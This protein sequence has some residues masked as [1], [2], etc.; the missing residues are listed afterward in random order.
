MSVTFAPWEPA[1]GRCHGSARPGATALMKVV[2][3][4]LDGLKSW[5]IY[6]CRDTALGNPSAHGDGRALDIGC[7]VAVGAALVKM[8]LR[9]GPSRL[10]IAVIIHNRKIYSAKSPEGRPYPG[11]PHLDHVHIELIRV[12]ANKMTAASIRRIISTAPP[13]KPSI[14]A[15]RKPGSRV[16]RNGSKGADVRWLQKRLG[17]PV[18]GFYGDKT[19][20]RVKRFQRRHD[21]PVDGSIGPKDWK[22][23]LAR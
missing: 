8:L 18:D 14:P 11:N 20:A 17:I 6:N 2:V 1:S 7:S 9:V 12:A 3:P 13:V 10:G 21:L 16:L 4:Q 5:G 22:E 23:L 15:P 19:E